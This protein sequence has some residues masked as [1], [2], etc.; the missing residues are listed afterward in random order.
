MVNPLENLPVWK[1]LDNIDYTAIPDPEFTREKTGG[2]SIEYFPAEEPEGVTYNNGY[3]RDH[4]MPGHDVILYNPDDNDEQDVR[5]DALHIMPKDPTY[6]ALNL[7]YRDAAREGDVA[8][9]AKQN[10]KED[11]SKYGKKSLDAAGMTPRQYFENEADGFLRSIL[12]EGD[13]EYRKSKRYYPDKQELAR[14]NSHLMPHVERIHNYLLTGERPPDI[15]PELIVT[16]QNAYGGNLLNKGG[17][18]RSTSNVG[19]VQGFLNLLDRK[20]IRYIKT[21]DY[22]KGAMTKS[23]HPS[24]HSQKDQWGNAR[25][26]DIWFTDFDKAKKT[27]YSDPELVAYLMDNKLGIL[28]E[29]TNAVKKKTGATLGPKRGNHFHIGPDRWAISMRDNA[30]RQFGTT[31]HPMQDVTWEDVQ[32]RRRRT[33]LTPEEEALLNTSALK[34]LNPEYVDRNDPAY[35]SAL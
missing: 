29:T 35:I 10:Y 26:A 27:I 19:G 13:S 5:L 28:E 34:T 1:A 16:N 11:L 3:H 30:I 14:H 17:N 23:G 12:M 20:G 22:R 15:L 24:W 32:A 21:S 31:Y 2:G 6:D 8:W 33:E 7:M 18:K 9:A 25:A 4:P